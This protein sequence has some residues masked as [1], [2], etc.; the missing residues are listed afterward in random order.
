MPGGV[1]DVPGLW[2][3]LREQEDVRMEFDEPRFSAKGFYHPN[4]DRPGTAV[5]S[6]VF[7]LDED[8]TTI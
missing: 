3:F 8:P 4:N 1:R 2:E 5:A 7:L 6:H